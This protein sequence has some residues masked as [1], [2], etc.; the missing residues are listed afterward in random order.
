MATN[1]RIPDQ[2]EPKSSQ[3]GPVLLRNPEPPRSAV[4]GVILA[5]ITAVL[6]LAAIFY[7]MPRAPRGAK[8][9]ASATAPTQPV[10]GQLQFSDMN[11]TLDPTGKSLDLDGEVTNSSNETLTGIMAEVRF[12]LQNGNFASVTAPVMAIDLGA[13]G[14]T[15]TKINDSS[16]NMVNDPIKPNQ[17]RA[18][19][20][21]VAQIPDGWNHTM[22]ALR[23]ITTTGMPG[24]PPKQKK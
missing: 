11:M 20:I 17:E 24:T 18:I 1:P 6:L 22:P 16:K 15:A 13:K 8:P 21:N 3:K 23:V 14:K 7:F 4:P 19:E 2:N 12:P 9:P 5:I 10:P